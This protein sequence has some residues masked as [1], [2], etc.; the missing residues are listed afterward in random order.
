MGGGFLL[1]WGGGGSGGVSCFFGATGNKGLGVFSRIAD[2]VC[3][4]QARARES[5]PGEE[6][7]HRGG[8]VGFPAAFGCGGSRGATRCSKYLFVEIVFRD[9]PVIDCTAEPLALFEVQQ[10]SSVCGL[11]VAHGCSLILWRC[12]T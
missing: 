7:A 2:V 11:E 5:S 9:G 1:K 6:G 3:A 8:S 10:A 4:V 12:W